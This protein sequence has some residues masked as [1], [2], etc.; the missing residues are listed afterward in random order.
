[1]KYGKEE[2]RDA[3]HALESA[4]VYGYEPAAVT[5]EVAL[6]CLRYCLNVQ[7]E[8]K[9]VTREHV[10]VPDVNRLYTSQGKTCRCIDVSQKVEDKTGDITVTYTLRRDNLWPEEVFGKLTP[11]EGGDA[12]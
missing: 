3:V 6:D 10:L 9:A 7:E 8:G 4:I 5:I 1:M 11:K 2:I 12:R